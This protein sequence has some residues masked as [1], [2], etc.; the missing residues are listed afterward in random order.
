MIALGYAGWGE[1][2]LDAELARPGWFNVA[3]DLALLYDAEAQARW[4]AGFES[5]G[6][7]PRLLAVGGGTA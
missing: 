3:G 4:T 5:A 2:Q 1:G 6:V 7:D